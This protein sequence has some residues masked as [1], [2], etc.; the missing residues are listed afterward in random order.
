MK[1][2]SHR[3]VFSGLLVFFIIGCA[4]IAQI[5]FAHLYGDSE[6]KQRQVD[7]LEANNVDYWQ[8]VQPVIESRCVV[9][10]ACYDAPC[11]LNMSSIE[12]IERGATPAKVYQGTRIL[13]APLTR[14]HLDAFTP[15]QWREKG[16]HS[17]LNEYASADAELDASLIHQMIALKEQGSSYDNDD[18]IDEEEIDLDIDASHQ[19]VQVES[20]HS[21][22]NKYPERGMPYG[23]PA[24]SSQEFK[25]ISTWLEQGALYTARPTLDMV[26]TDRVKQWEQ[27]LNQ[28]SMKAQLV[29][30]YIYEHLFLGHLYFD[31]LAPQFFKLVRS[32]T[33]A[34]ASIEV[35]A[36]RRP[37]DDPKVERVYYRLAPVVD[38]IVNKTHMPYALNPQRKALWQ[39]LFF[40]TDYS[41]THLPSYQPEVAANP[42]V[43]Y[44]QLPIK[45]RYKF[46]LDEAQF[47]IMGFIKGPV[48]RG[49][50]ALN[51][52]NDHFWVYFTDPDVNLAKE[53]SDFLLNNHELLELPATKE[54]IYLPLTN[55]VSYADQ[56]QAFF[57]ARDNFF[58]QKQAENIANTGKSLINLNV[59]WNGEFAETS[60]KN[61]NAAL[62]I[63]RHYNSA[64][65]AKGLVGEKPKT[66]WLIGYTQLERIHYLLV[67]GFDV[68]GNAG[69]QLLSRVYMDFLRMESESNYLQLLPNQ[70][71]EQVRQYWYRGASDEVNR[72][73][74]LPKFER[75]AEPDINYVTHSPADELI[76]LLKQRLG[77]AI[78]TDLSSNNVA[79]TSLIQLQQL[80]S[81][82]I[83]LLSEYSILQ[84]NDD[85]VLGT[86]YYSLLRNKAHSNITSIFNEQNNRLPDEDTVSLLPG[87][88]ASY[89]NTFWSIDYRQLSAF[90]QAINQ[91]EDESDYR[92]LME[93][94]GIRRTHPDFWDFSD[95][96]H[97]DFSVLSPHNAG[98][99]DFNRLENR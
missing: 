21:Y 78:N 23:L 24:I 68:F 58:S 72:Y 84:V 15:A 22:A 16:F 63:Y 62:T 36:T 90:I 32:K 74:R 61:D 52:I 9:C 51:V 55:W 87:I 50:V 47:T 96:L 42:F 48:C 40:D 13:P 82:A 83:K 93:D 67:A 53:Y 45:S 12:G 91:L 49:Q 89:P 88:V 7:T 70:T 1:W 92:D 85:P 59:V 73:M 95:E 29:S 94:Y 20:F 2:M 10:H 60:D 26:Y 33:K 8:D 6:P 17:V 18:L 38:A 79:H 97:Q 11:Q 39:Q 31:D 35:I 81:A 43:A 25:Q 86:Q 57:K 75:Q 66:S 30:R 98:W 56:Q 64:T 5:N 41:V 14:L 80:P 34:P 69:H 19:C 4:S 27:F 37:Y 54:N 46:M 3:L 76:T 28:D 65:V 77:S 99:L 71:R 44:D